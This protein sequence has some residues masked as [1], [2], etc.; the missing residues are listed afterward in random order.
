MAG[1]IFSVD[2]G[3]FSGAI[4]RVGGDRDT[5]ESANSQ[6]VAQFK[7][8]E[9]AWQSPAGESFTTFLTDLVSATQQ[10]QQLLDDMVSRMQTTYHNY[11]NAESTNTSN[12][13]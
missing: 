7:A 4:G 6:I 2:L 3:E 12:L 5:I 13:S 11:S 8:V 10:L 1:N 9:A